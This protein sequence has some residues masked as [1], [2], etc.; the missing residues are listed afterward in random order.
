M[1]DYL[2]TGVAGFIGSNLAA[3]LLSRGYTVR[4]L[5]N[6]STGRRSNVEGLT[7]RE[8][9]ELV[10]GELLDEATVRDVVADV[11]YVLHQGAVPSVPRSIDDPVTTTTV[12]CVGTTKLLVAARDAGVDRVVVA[13]SSSVYGENDEIPKH[14][15]LNLEPVSIYALTKL[16]TE[17]I[18]IQFS[19][20]Y[21]LDTVALRYFNVFGPRQDPQSQYAAVI[22]K[23]IL[24]ML[25]GR[26][27]VI[28]GDGEQSR[29]FTYVENVVEAN[30]AAAESE[31]SGEAINVGCG[32]QIPINTL[33]EELNSVLGTRIKPEYDDPRPGDVRHS[34]ADIGKAK[35]LLGYEPLVGFRD[36][37]ER[38]VAYFQSNP[39]SH[40]E[41]A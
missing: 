21:G 41:N 22:P 29:D 10:E 13:S 33:V 18:A 34:K 39:S 4:G 2:V 31:T 12:N 28:Y 1:S 8:R 9:F 25:Q 17:R 16:W 40:T 32:D 14:E 3:E 38:T 5:D 23:F 27:P 24:R 35:K 37:L 36:G 19:E 30:I 7:R 20:Y 15:G 11:D 6:F 26:R